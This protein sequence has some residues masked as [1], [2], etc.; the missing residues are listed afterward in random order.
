MKPSIKIG[1]AKSKKTG[2]EYSYLQVTIGDYEGR[3]FP[4]KAECS[5]IQSLM[6]QDARQDFQKAVEEDKD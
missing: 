2:K 5:Y 4:S 3:L 1:T 6:R